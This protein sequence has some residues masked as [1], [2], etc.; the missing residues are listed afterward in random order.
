M[1][2][3]SFLRAFT[4]VRDQS[5]FF[6]GEALVSAPKQELWHIKQTLVIWISST[7]VSGKVYPVVKSV[8][9]HVTIPKVIMGRRR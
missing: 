8:T 7:A 2:A 6:D 5:S 1:Y 9:V 4:I 3:C